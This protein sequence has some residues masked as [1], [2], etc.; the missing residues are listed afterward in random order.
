MCFAFEVKP[1]L[2]FQVQV[3]ADIPRDRQTCGF[4]TDEVV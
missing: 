3:E 2:E 1:R 4:Q